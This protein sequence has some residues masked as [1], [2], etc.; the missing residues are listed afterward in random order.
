[1]DN[2]LVNLDRTV[3]P[4]IGLSEVF[5]FGVGFFF[6]AYTD[7]ET[8]ITEVESGGEGGE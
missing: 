4:L 6:D 7:I 8:G 2:S 1:M 3:G 5:S